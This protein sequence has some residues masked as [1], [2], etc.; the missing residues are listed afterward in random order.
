MDELTAEQREIIRKRQR[1][2]Y[3]TLFKSPE[4]VTEI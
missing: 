1:L 2:E 3:Y 4:E